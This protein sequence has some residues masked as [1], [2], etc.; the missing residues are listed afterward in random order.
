[1]NGNDDFAKT[2]LSVIAKGVALFVGV[3]LIL[4]IGWLAWILILNSQEPS[5]ADHKAA[6]AQ[7]AA[8]KDELIQWLSLNDILFSDKI[9]TAEYR[10]ALLESKSSGLP[11]TSFIS[12]AERNVNIPGELIPKVAS[13]VTFTLTPRLEKFVLATSMLYVVLFYDQDGCLIFGGYDH[14]YRGM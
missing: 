14:S 6:I 3:P 10:D 8:A 9:A 2:V 4:V 7:H 12:T 5:A 11:T 13:V 1:M